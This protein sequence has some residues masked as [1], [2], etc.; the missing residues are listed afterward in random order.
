MLV[1]GGRVPRFAPNKVILWDE[2][3]IERS[4]G[5]TEASV[6]RGQGT[7]R[8]TVEDSSDND[9]DDDD[10]APSTGG[11]TLFSV[12][13]EERERES[14]VGETEPEPQRDAPASNLLAESQESTGLARLF[15]Q[16]SQASLGKSVPDLAD[17]DSTSSM[18]QST[19]T[20]EGKPS[21][22]TTSTA[23]LEDPFVADELTGRLPDSSK[24]EQKVDASSSS[25]ESMPH[26]ASAST[27]LD[28]SE[29][30]ASLPRRFIRRG[31][32]VAELEFGEAVQGI[33]AR[34]FQ[35]S[36]VSA[37]KEDKGKGKEKVTRLAD[38]EPTREERQTQLLAGTANDLCSLLVVILPKK[39]IVFELGPHLD[40][41][42]ST[43]SASSSASS[44]PPSW[45]IRKRLQVDI[46]PG[47]KGLVS[48]APMVT[49]R[50][51]T[52]TS[53][54]VALPGRQ[55]GHVQMIRV[56]LLAHKHAAAGTSSI[57]AAHST[58]LANLTLSDCGRYLCTASERG[59]LLRIWSTYRNSTTSSSSSTSSSSGSG[60]GGAGMRSSRGKHTFGAMLLVELRRG[61]DPAKILSVAFSGD[62][63]VLAAASDKG[64]IHFFALENLERDANLAAAS[65]TTS[66]DAAQPS[67]LHRRSA[68]ASLSALSN[69]YLPTAINNL[70]SQ[71]PP[72]ML[73]TYL[74]SQ[75]SDSQY[76]IPLRTF[77]PSVEDRAL[78]SSSASARR[79]RARRM[80]GL[81][82]Y[83]AGIVGARRPPDDE[84]D[85]DVETPRGGA[86]VT[87]SMEG[88]WVALKGRIEDVRR[89]EVG[90]EEE[91]FLTWVHAGKP[92]LSS[93]LAKSEGRS[94]A[95]RGE[96]A[97]ETQGGE[98]KE[99]NFHLVAITTSG[100]WYRIAFDPSPMPSAND[101]MGSST[102]LDMYRDDHR[103]SSQ[104]ES[105]AAHEG[106]TMVTQEKRCWLV[107]QRRFALGG[108]W[109]DS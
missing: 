91:I 13:R 77:S 46:C 62:N 1:G 88:N 36:A 107:E 82:E 80:R 70:A 53:A 24:V 26:S 21:A 14:S 2:D 58:S 54:L 98:G 47:S 40:E 73:P 48:V 60:A 4:V 65:P 102:V 30:I 69:K 75:W 71:I 16:D 55:P 6:F 94:K 29:Q 90:K 84:S 38:E 37:S 49:S 68:G 63:R 105:E 9:D 11:S 76:R 92:L 59:T 18:H 57:I 95:K 72:S 17:E 108:E 52:P 44:S 8:D 61:S 78:S 22:L 25:H 15:G 31:R 32:E 109:S 3:A 106:S 42:S 5:P 50:S 86:G 74:K 85:G 64:T 89:G 67:Q 39:A 56:P 100:G 99:T 34:T 103:A 27:S 81:P 51:K 43:G 12:G 79:R 96:T 20:S 104:V 33:C 101:T 23:D 19:S 7:P 93:A 87:R 28:Q 41:Q 66:H 35:T 83:A 97:V 10:G 45:G